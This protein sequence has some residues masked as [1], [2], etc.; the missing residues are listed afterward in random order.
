MRVLRGLAHERPVLR[1]P[2]ASWP[3]ISVRDVLVPVDVGE[4]LLAGVLER[5][6]GVEPDEPERFL[7]ALDV[8][9]VA[10]RRPWPASRA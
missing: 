5:L 7:E 4:P 10:V 9:R 6:F 1:R 3:A 8:D 2:R